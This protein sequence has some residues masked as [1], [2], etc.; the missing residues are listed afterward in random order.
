[1][2]QI[3]AII[4]FICINVSIT[5][6]GPAVDEMEFKDEMQNLEDIEMQ[7]EVVDDLKI[8]LDDLI[9]LS[10]RIARE[11]ESDEFQLRLLVYNNPY[12]E[13]QINQ[14]IDR[15][16]SV[17]KEIDFYIIRYNIEYEK[18]INMIDSYNYDPHN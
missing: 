12:K 17:I 10:K 1:M 6:C 2:I 8:K 13:N 3:L 5:A 14:K 9:T 15:Y 18:L 16:N 7:E 4:I 11:I